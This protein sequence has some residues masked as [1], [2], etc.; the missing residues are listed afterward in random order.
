MSARQWSGSHDRMLCARMR[1]HS[2]HMI[3]FLRSDTAICEESQQEEP[4]A[5]RFECDSPPSDPLP[6]C[7]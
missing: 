2:E 3:A 4:R 5:D 1:M 7:P 6:L